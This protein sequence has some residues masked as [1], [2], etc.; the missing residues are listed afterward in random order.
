M[1]N[2]GEHRALTEVYF[3][4]KLNANLISLGQL[5]EHG[6]DSDYHCVH[7]MT[8]IRSAAKVRCNA[9]RLYLLKLMTGRPALLCPLQHSYTPGCGTLVSATFI[10]MLCASSLTRTWCAV[11]RSSTRATRRRS[12]ISSTGVSLL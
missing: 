6:C 11:A 8:Q 3:I 7:T 5:D 1:C 10:L 9:N 4:P 2:N 12:I